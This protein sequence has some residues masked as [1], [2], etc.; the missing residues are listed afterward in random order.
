MRSSGPYT[1][2]YLIAN[3]NFPNKTMT[4][5]CLT[6]FDGQRTSHCHQPSGG[7]AKRFSVFIHR[8]N[9]ICAP[10]PLSHDRNQVVGCACRTSLRLNHNTIYDVDKYRE[11]QLICSKTRYRKTETPGVVVW[12]LRTR[13]GIRGR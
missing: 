1:S 3:Y 5:Q 9:L 7:G 6:T 8:S 11:C 12:K 10:Q 4:V 13:K 2:I